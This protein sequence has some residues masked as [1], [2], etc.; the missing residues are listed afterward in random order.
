[1]A[2]VANE[3]YRFLYPLRCFISQYYTIL[4]KKK[5]NHLPIIDIKECK[6]CQ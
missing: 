5:Y 6:I 3:K 1:M 4:N 2:I